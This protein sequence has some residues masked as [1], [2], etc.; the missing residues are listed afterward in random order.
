MQPGGIIAF[1]DKRSVVLAFVRKDEGKQLRVLNEKGKA[2]PYPKARVALDLRTSRDAKLSPED[3]RRELHAVRKAGEE[4]RKEVDLELLWESVREDL[5]EGGSMGDLAELYF[6]DEPSAA[7]RLGLLI[8]LEADS[9]YFKRKGDQLV[10]KDADA[11]QETLRQQEEAARKAEEEADALVW[12]QFRLSGRDAPEPPGAARLIEILRQVAVLGDEFPDMAKAQQ[13]F[14]DFGSFGPGAAFDYLVTLG[15]FDEH[16][17]LSLHAY[18][19]PVEFPAEVLAAAGEAAP[20]EEKRTD[21]RHLETV[22]IDDADTTE[23]DDALSLETREGGGTRLWVH[24]A[25]ASAFV[26]KG[27]V[28]DAHAARRSTSVYLPEKVIPMMPPALA[29]EACSLQAGK[30]RPALSL[31]VDLDAEGQIEEHT[32]LASTIQVDRAITYEEVEA[33]LDED[34]LLKAIHTVSE[35]QRAIRTEAGA[36]SYE[37]QELRVKV[38]DGRIELKKVIGDSK[39]QVLVSEMMVLANRLCGETL[40]DAGVP[41]L[42]KRQN[43]PKE[44]GAGYI[45]KSTLGLEAGEHYGLGLPVY[46]QMTSPIRRYGDLAMHR[47]LAKVIG[48]PMES[49]SAEELGPVLATCQER[50]SA[51][52]AAQR[53]GQKYWTLRYIERL[54]D[55][56]V[57]AEVNHV[58]RGGMVG[59]RLLDFLLPSMLPVPQ[60]KSLKDGDRVKVRVTS[61]DARRGRV[62]LRYLAPLPT[63]VDAVLA[64]EKQAE[65]S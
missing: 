1:V 62:R 6:G 19:I 37:R 40:R 23:V 64:Q 65:S 20:I 22:S 11:V 9:A 29:M 30:E 51:A 60:G 2:F 32:F 63:D 4:A 5:P 57:A 3:V 33:G 45:P 10:P 54:A 36:T 8:D 35:R 21:L 50:E 27:S 58:K 25:D 53:E 38:E 46:C 24:I 61:V 39:G 55:K 34:P 48:R 28:V 14:K 18:E 43:A 12:L 13:L 49:H 56:D 17:N 42:Y 15:I 41:A 47:Q 16:E 59:C 26:P 52:I 7:Q 44:G 31:R